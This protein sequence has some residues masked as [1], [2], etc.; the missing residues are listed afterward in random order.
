MT[1]TS[2]AT[3]A[4]RLQSALHGGADR[5]TLGQVVA[6]RRSIPERIDVQQPVPGGGELGWLQ[7]FVE[8][9]GIAGSRHH[10]R[11]WLIILC[12]VCCWWCSCWL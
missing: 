9:A 5:R 6:L 7:V 4:R 12:C 3:L 8:T 11:T 10:Q 2:R 1:L